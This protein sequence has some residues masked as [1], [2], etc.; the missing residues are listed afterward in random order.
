MIPEPPRI[1][2]AFEAAIAERESFD[3][4][5]PHHLLD[6][7]VPQRRL[8]RAGGIC[9][10]RR[11]CSTA[12]RASANCTTT[13]AAISTP[14]ASSGSR[15][16]A[17]WPRRCNRSRAVNAIHDA[18]AR[19]F[20]GTFLRL[21]YAQDVDGFW[22]QPHTDLGVKKFTCLIYLSDGPGHETLGTDIY[23]TPGQAFRRLAVPAR[24]RDGVRA[25]RR[26]LA[27]LREAA[28]S[29]ACAAR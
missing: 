3:V 29:R 27:R 8:R 25:R 22:L 2:A 21:E 6:N 17:R 12:S 10:S 14:A 9:R 20:D 16:W 28:R 13:S 7:R 23:E 19:R 1:A 11:R 15:S 18:F 4:P 26:H 5:Y 24:R